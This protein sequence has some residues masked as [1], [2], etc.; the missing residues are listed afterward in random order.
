MTIGTAALATSHDFD[1]GAVTQ[2]ILYATQMRVHPA[3]LSVSDTLKEALIEEEGVRHTVYRDAAGLPTVGVGHLVTPQD[4]LTVGQRIGSDRIL[5]LF[6]R[7]L[8]I[9]EAAAKR[10]A[11][12]LPLYQ[13]EFD[14]LVDLIF[15][16]GEGKVSEQQSPRLNAAIL[17]GNYDGIASELEYHHAGGAKVSGLVHRSERRSNIFMD[18]LYEDPREANGMRNA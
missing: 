1:D 8:A 14:A 15:N 2:D 16:V 9:A 4:R 11:G 5:D 3:Q 18:A 10:L 13:H 7:D 6:D 12:N 17:A